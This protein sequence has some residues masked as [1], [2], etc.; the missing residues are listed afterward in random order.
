MWP[1]MQDQSKKKSF[2]FPPLKWF[3]FSVT[4]LTYICI[5]LRSIQIWQIKFQFHVL[6]ISI[7]WCDCQL[8][9]RLIS[10]HMQGHNPRGGHAEEFQLH[11]EEA[12]HHLHPPG[13]ACCIMN[14][15]KHTL[16]MRIHSYGTQEIWIIA[17]KWFHALV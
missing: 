7:S 1:W 17:I 11:L 3:M 16:T 5:F 2:S 15:D 13:G 8:H 14:N 9:L 12:D 10:L 4:Q 6:G